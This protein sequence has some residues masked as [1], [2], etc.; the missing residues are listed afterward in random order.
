ML[1]RRPIGPG[2][3]VRTRLRRVFWSIFSGLRRQDR[4]APRRLSGRDYSATNLLSWLSLHRRVATGVSSAPF[5]RA[6]I[7]DDVVDLLVGQLALNR[8]HQP[9]FDDGEIADGSFEVG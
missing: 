7:T 4:F 6:Q 8:R 9:F 1:P 2:H 5:Q 3:R